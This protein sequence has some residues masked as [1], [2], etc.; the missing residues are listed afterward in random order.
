MD[1]VKAVLTQPCRAKALA[2]TERSRN[3][4]K[5]LLGRIDSRRDGR[6]AVYVGIERKQDQAKGETK[7]RK[8]IQ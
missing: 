3:F 1:I 7:M 8:N 4:A 2:N 6:K 5:Y